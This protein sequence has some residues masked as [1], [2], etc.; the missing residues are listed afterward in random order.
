MGF[1]LENNADKK[2]K[3][4]RIAFYL[5]LVGIFSYSVAARLLFYF[6]RP[7]SVMFAMIFLAITLE[8]S[9]QHF[10][11]V[12]PY[13]PVSAILAALSS[14]LIIDATSATPYFMATI[15]A[16]LS[17]FFIRVDGRHLYNPSNFGIVVMLILYEGNLNLSGMV[18]AGS[19]AAVVIFFIAGFIISLMAGQFFTVLFWFLNF[20]FFALVRSDFSFADF[21]SNIQILTSASMLLFSFNMIT[22]PRTA[23]TSISRQFIYTFFM[24]AIDMI[25][26]LFF[27]PY[28][29]FYGLFI[30]LSLM[31][32]FRACFQTQRVSILPKFCAT[33]W[34][35]FAAVS[36]IQKKFL[37]KNEPKF[38]QKRNVVG[39]KTGST[40][41]CLSKRGEKYFCFA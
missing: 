20:C 27:I 41:R 1:F 6:E 23:P 38:G 19:V 22:D 14:S 4:L 35:N 39:L 15:L 13:F 28:G 26:R 18:F 7:L 30:V 2:Q 36:G 29:N 34:Q 31:P 33:F 9:I 16:I 12:K 17:K 21:L 10:R 32:I 8:L 25:F 37:P 24:A 3:I 40:M 5:Q 11:G